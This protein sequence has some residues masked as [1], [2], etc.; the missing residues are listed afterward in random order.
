MIKLLM[1]GHLGKDCLVKEV[2]GKNVMSFT[3]AH[4][5]K[6]KDQQGTQKEKTTWVNCDYWSDRTGIAPYLKKGTQVF[7][8]GFPEADAYTNKEGQAAASLRLRVMN[9]QLLGS[10]PEG[11]QAT[12]G[13]TAP[14]NT[15]N[16]ASG[17]ATAGDADDLPF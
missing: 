11:A 13:T 1:I 14:A 17:L 15:A 5:E 8:E 9:I 12:N 3:I 4:T 6:F 16:V 2:N 10:K 7:V